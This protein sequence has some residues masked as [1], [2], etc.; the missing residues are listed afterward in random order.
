VPITTE[1]L[2]DIMMSRRSTARLLGLMFVIPLLLTPMKGCGSCTYGA[3]LQICT[4]VAI[5]SGGDAG[6]CYA[7]CDSGY[8]PEYM[9]ATFGSEYA[10]AVQSYLSASGGGITAPGRGSAEEFMR[11][12]F[13]DWETRRADLLERA[14]ASGLVPT[15]N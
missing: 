11:A 4:A 6:A 9:V 2:E 14:A 8:S 13:A 5:L 1:R 15:V 3:G 12:R 7:D 10:E